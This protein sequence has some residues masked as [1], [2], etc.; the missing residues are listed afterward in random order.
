MIDKQKI[1]I[2]DDDLD[3]SSA[4]QGLL[5]SR[6]YQVT[7]ACNGKEGFEL[8]LSLKPDLMLLD[9]MMTYDNEGFELAK[10]LS[11]EEKTRQIPVILITG[12]RKAK[13]LPFAFEPDP[14]WLPVR[15]VLEKPV[16]FDDFLDQVAKA[17]GS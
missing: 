7:T 15:A 11:E 9:V 10:K 17:L 12:I 14:E 3:F 6:G 8:A 1:L 4:M 2:V 13:N 5:E 16:K